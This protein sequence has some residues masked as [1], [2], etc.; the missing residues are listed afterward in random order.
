MTNAADNETFLYFAYG[1]NMLTRRLAGRT[2]SAKKEGIGYVEGRRLAFDKVSSDGSGKADI[3]ITDKQTDRVYG[4]LFKIARTEEGELDAHEGLNKGYRKDTVQV[5]M[6]SGKVAAQTY[7]ATK[8]D[9]TR[10]P[11]DWYKAFVV[12][13][14]VEHSLPHGY[15]EK[16]RTVA[17][18]PDPDKKRRADNEEILS[19]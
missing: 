1:S 13:G 8:K 15:V 7:I 5:V 16:L 10:F 12:A 4:V 11:Y 2:P 6:E 17:S 19:P 18:K 9:S 14:A 3:E